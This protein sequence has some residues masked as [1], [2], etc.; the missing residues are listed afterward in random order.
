MR[1]VGTRAYW[2]YLF[3]NCV[4]NRKIESWD[5][6]RF[7]GTRSLPGILP[8]MC[9]PQLGA[10]SGVRKALRPHQFPP[11]SLCT[12]PGTRRA[13]LPGQL[14]RTPHGVLPPLGS[15]PLVNPDPD[16]LTEAGKGSG[17]GVVMILSP[18]SLRAGPAPAPSGL[19]HLAIT[20]ARGL[21]SLCTEGTPS[22][23]QATQLGGSSRIRMQASAQPQPQDPSRSQHRGCGSRCFWEAPRSTGANPG[24]QRG[25]RHRVW[26]FWPSAFLYGLGR[27]Q[28]SWAPS[29]QIVS[30]QAAGGH[31]GCCASTSI[32]AGTQTRGEQGQSR[33]AAVEF[34]GSDRGRSMAS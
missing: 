20:W 10:C 9:R 25:P 30:V 29:R 11:D 8:A 28:V 3:P 22:H 23:R 14:W 13:F 2:I 21:P 24:P 5:M 6:P 12:P 4:C 26:T 18:R 31:G 15:A 27:G 33:Q 16:P 7:L 17:V 1:A 32:P 34:V 19:L